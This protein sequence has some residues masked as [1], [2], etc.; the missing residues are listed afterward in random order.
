MRIQTTPNA[1]INQLDD[2]GLMVLSPTGRVYAGN[3][4]AAV[5]WTALTTEAGD[6]IAAATGIARRYRVPVMRVRADLDHFVSTLRA[7]GAVT[8]AP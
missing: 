7:A 8:A 4:M 2:G 5:M 6:P 1:T 3:R